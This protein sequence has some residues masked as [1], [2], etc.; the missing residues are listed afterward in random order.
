MLTNLVQIGL[1]A[2]TIPML[3][4]NEGDSPVNDK[5]H[6]LGARIHTPKMKKHGT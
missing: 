3:G 5:R 4:V 2:G 1:A 6:V